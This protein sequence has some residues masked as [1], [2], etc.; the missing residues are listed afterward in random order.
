MIHITIDLY[1]FSRCIWTSNLLLIPRSGFPWS[2][3]HLVH[4]ISIREVGQWVPSHLGQL[5]DTKAMAS[6]LPPLPSPLLILLAMV[7]RIY[8]NRCHR[9]QP[10][11]SKS[12]N[13]QWHTLTPSLNLHRWTPHVSLNLHRTQVFSQ[14]ATRLENLSYFIYSTH[15]SHLATSDYCLTFLLYTDLPLLL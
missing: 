12:I 13:F 10:L 3:F 14:P 5:L 8:P 6:F 1:V 11:H 2:S 7:Q 4:L 15:L 9:T